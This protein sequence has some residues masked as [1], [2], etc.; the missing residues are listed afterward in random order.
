MI[1]V[2]KF[3]TFS[4]VLEV[5]PVRLPEFLETYDRV[6]SWISAFMVPV[7]GHSGQV[8][9]APTMQLLQPPF[10][11]RNKDLQVNVRVHVQHQVPG[12]QI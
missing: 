4:F 9:G 3:Q 8:N 10:D 2:N 11:D 6:G 12:S 7:P 5:D 1:P